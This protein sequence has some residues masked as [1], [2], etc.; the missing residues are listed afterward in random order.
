MVRSLGQEVY[1]RDRLARQD[2]AQGFLLAAWEGDVAVGDVYVWL[3]PAE[4]PELRA[5][6]PGVPLLTHLEVVPWRRNRGIGTLLLW[7]AEDRLFADGHDQ[8]ALGVRLDNLDAQRLYRRRGYV[9][10]PHGQVPTTEVVYHP[11]GECELR[12]EVCR[13]MI[14]HLG[15]NQPWDR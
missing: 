2:A 5:L 13:I 9:E 11:D 1:F 7:E 4:E 15:Q 12:P 10:W 6:L 14:R 8:V 3:A